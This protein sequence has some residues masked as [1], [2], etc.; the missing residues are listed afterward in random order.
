METFIFELPDGRELAFSEAGA[1]DGTP[2]LAFHGTPGSRRQVLLPLADE[3]AR[4]AGVR[5][6]APDR[7]G[8][9][10]STFQRGRRLVDWAADVASLADHLDLGHFAVI[11]ISG[12]GPHAL[13][14]A[15]L[16]ADRVNRAG[17][18]SGIGPTLSSEDSEDM[19][20]SNQILFALAR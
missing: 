5:L 13:V 8:Y 14:C 20:R 16:L 2:V 11:G 19:M 9:G 17:V 1:A 18:V 7:P 10:H 3:A 12:G 4:K 15:A 6:I